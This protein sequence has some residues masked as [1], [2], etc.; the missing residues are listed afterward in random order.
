MKSLLL[1]AAAFLAIDSVASAQSR[2]TAK[3]VSDES[4]LTRA[5]NCENILHPT[6]KTTYPVKDGSLTIQVPAGMV[7]VPGGPFKFGNGSDERTATLDGYCIGKFSVTNSEYKEFLTATDSRRF[8]R[9]WTNGT[10]PEGKANHPV[11]YVSLNDAQA[12]AKWV[13]E[14]T[15][16]NFV[17]PTSEQWEKAAR[18]PQGFLYPW[19]NELDTTYRNGVLTSRFSFNSV[20]A[21][22]FLKDAPKRVVKY[23]N[24]K[25]SYFGK[26][27][28]VDQ[29]AGFSR[30]GQPNYLSVGPNGS[31]RGWV[32]HDTYTGF[33]YTDLFS[34]LNNQGG[35]TV[36]V[37]S[38]E[39]GKSEY[40]CYEMAGNV[41]N[42]CDTLIVAANGAEK[43]KKVNDIRG[44]S[45]YA[46]AT[47]CK[48]IC[49]GEGR[50]ASGAYNTVGFR[51]ALNPGK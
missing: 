5:G 27:T 7:H 11:I 45:W 15:G 25:S 50:A 40:G 44:G 38:Y 24:Q 33:I 28:P 48:S 6:S 43:G 18:G 19:G 10:Y 39:N 35:N 4:V 16:W 46:N 42:W 9:H 41:W 17:I 51:V 12:Y 23:D 30:D 1:T 47:S 14:K 3:A 2:A 49:I 31:V 34:S 22:Q 36:A 21:A 13:S 8:P 32:N 29:I 37:G 20:T 26:T